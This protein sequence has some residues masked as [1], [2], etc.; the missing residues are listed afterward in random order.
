M[1][2]KPKTS[3]ASE[4]A[5]HALTDVAHPRRSVNALVH[6]DYERFDAPIGDA[7]CQARTTVVSDAAKV[8]EDYLE[9]Y[10]DNSGGPEK[11]KNHEAVLALVEA[12]NTLHANDPADGRVKEPSDLK[13][14]GRGSEEY[15][16]FFAEI[17]ALLG[18]EHL[19]LLS[20]FYSK[21]ADYT[22]TFTVFDTAIAQQD[23]LIYYGTT[24]EAE[25]T[26][27]P[28]LRTDLDS[29]LKAAV[30]QGNVNYIYRR[31]NDDIVILGLTDD[32]DSIKRQTSRW[33]AE[34]Y[35]AKI[36]LPNKQTYEVG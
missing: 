25:A 17:E 15:E 8:V 20:A 18:S 31:F 7:S 34:E 30:G 16:R 1:S 28:R 5:I 2:Y 23:H 22:R 6:R 36:T 21:T 19:A 11:Q 14:E 26:K 32:S 4:Q 3:F 24:A 35:R 9:G 12:Y 10:M 27:N 33:L 13:N 29:T